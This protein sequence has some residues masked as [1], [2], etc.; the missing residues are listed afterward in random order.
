MEEKYADLLLK[1]CLQLKKGDQLFVNSTFLAEPLLKE[2]YRLGT[3]LGALV[4]FDL[5]LEEQS[6]IFFEEA[7]DD[8]IRL[9]S[10][11]Q[12]YRYRH[13]NKYLNIRAPYNLSEEKSIPGDKLKTRKQATH[14]IH[15]LY[16]QRTADGSMD[17]CLCQYPTQ[18]SAQIAEMSLEEYRKFVFQACRLYDDNPVNSWLEVRREQQQITDLLNKSTWIQYQGPHID[19]SFSCKDRIWINSDG[20]ANMPSGEIF[21][22][23]VD[24]STQGSVYFTYPAIYRGQEVS[25]ISLT[26]EDGYIT[27]WSAEKGESVLDE[28]F[29]IEGARRLGEAAIGNNYQIRQMTKNILFDEKIGGSIHLAVGQAYLQNNGTNESVIHWDMITDMKEDSRILA[30]G[31]TIYEN[32]HFII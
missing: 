4:E 5:A 1:Y 27:K 17:R 29:D 18:A 31:K 22:A 26:F 19:I 9:I 24:D 6:R 11:V 12:E 25:G 23:P 2:V 13:F 28:V 14:P 3:R 10:P 8:L 21:T 20:R 16:F 30:D 15:S 32:G 7:D